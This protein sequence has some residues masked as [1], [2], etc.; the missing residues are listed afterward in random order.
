MRPKIFEKR[1]AQKIYLGFVLPLAVLLVA[2]ILVPIFV[3][4]SLD[5]FRADYQ[6][7]EFLAA[8]ANALRSAAISIEEQASNLRSF[9]DPRFRQ[10][11][12]DARLVYR[13]DLIEV[14]GRIDAIGESKV[15]EL[16]VEADR[17]YRTWFQSTAQGR[18]LLSRSS[19]CR[20]GSTR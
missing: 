8:R 11:L 6:E 12:F 2:G 7:R 9:K 19:R 20:R 16:L 14:Q 13:D 4:F 15:Q 3:W 1:I 5:R 10:E 17:A 18:K